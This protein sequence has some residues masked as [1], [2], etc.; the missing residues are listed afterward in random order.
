MGPGG[1][2]WDRTIANDEVLGDGR[3][4]GGVAGLVRQQAREVREEN[5]RQAEL[6][7][8]RRE[9]FAPWPNGKRARATDD[10][11]AGL[12]AIRTVLARMCVLLHEWIR[13]RSLL[14]VMVS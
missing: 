8:P 12:G 9:P 2:W 1:H 14:K 6:L 4:E 10:C 13:R 11:S 3:G 7:R 5:T